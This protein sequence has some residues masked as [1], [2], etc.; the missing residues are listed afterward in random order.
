MEDYYQVFSDWLS[1]RYFSKYK[2][3]DFIG[4]ELDEMQKNIF[5]KF[6]FDY[7]NMKKD[8]FPFPKYQVF[9]T[10]LNFNEVFL[11]L[12][13]TFFV[14]DFPVKIH[15][16]TLELNFH[17]IKTFNLNFAKMVQ[18]VREA[19]Q[20]FSRC[21]NIKNLSPSLRGCKVWK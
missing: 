13:V 15:I 20:I 1:K 5:S 9:E 7:F 21:V 11:Y 18:R 2:G 3:E 4:E 8:E 10:E 14:G 6:V 19:S 12:H 17:D 16:A